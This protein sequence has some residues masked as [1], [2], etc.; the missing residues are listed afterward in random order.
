VFLTQRQ[1]YP[2]KIGPLF[3]TQENRLHIT[4]NTDEGL[5]NPTAERIDN[6]M[7]MLKKR[8]GHGADF[9]LLLIVT[10]TTLM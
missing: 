7:G 10:N 8:R 5:T 3:S 6:P 2:Q 1:A 4:N 9:L